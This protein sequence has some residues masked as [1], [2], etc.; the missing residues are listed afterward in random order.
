MA[1]SRMDPERPIVR[2]SVA[3]LILWASFLGLTA[4]R[5][6][7]PADVTVLPSTPGPTRYRIDLNRADW[8]ELTLIAGIG[9]RLARRIVT[10]RGQVGAF[11]SIEEVMALPGVPDRPF[12]DARPY[13]TLSTP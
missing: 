3:Y 12:Q 2:R 6:I 8:P 7:P 1:T 9:E 11:R 5:Q 4:W 13:L 10:A